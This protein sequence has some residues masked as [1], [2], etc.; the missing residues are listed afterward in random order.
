MVQGKTTTISYKIS[1]CRNI[2]Q[3]D[4]IV[5]EDTHEAI[6]DRETFEKAQA[7]FD[8]YTRSSPQK[9]EK[10]LFAGFLRC[11]DCHAAMG[12]KTN[13][14]SYGTYHYYRCSTARKTKRS[15]CSN[16]TIRLDKLEAAVLKTI[17][18]MIEVAVM[19]DRLIKHIN[20]SPVKKQESSHIHSAI[21]T[22]EKELAKFKQMVLDLY[23]DLKGG[24]I[25]REEYLHLKEQL[26]KKNSGLER[27]L[28]SLQASQEEFRSGL[29]E[30]NEFITHF[31]KY[32]T[33]EKLSR[34]MLMELVDKIYIHE[35][36]KITI[37]F[38]FEDAYEEALE[39]IN[40]NYEAIMTA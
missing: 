7:L 5:V 39:F 35:D 4:W 25:S 32:G 18:S 16:H 14:H 23:P 22:H 12:K 19:M 10:D 11:A 24:L 15:A 34:S 9:K 37:K 20:N 6:I 2:P 26:N 31:T 28:E 33:V 1:K 13:S 29:F 36:N 8:K 21:E 38:K 30:D 27:S 17:Q 3:S 40:L